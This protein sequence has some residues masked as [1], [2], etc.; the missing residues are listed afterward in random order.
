MNNFN[1]KKHRAPHFWV[2]LEDGFNNVMILH[3]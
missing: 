2:G 1:K 3:A